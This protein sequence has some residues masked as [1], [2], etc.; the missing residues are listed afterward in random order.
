ML[1]DASNMFWTMHMQVQLQ[2]HIVCN[3]S[4]YADDA[5]LMSA[6]PLKGHT[7]LDI[8]IAVGRQYGKEF[9]TIT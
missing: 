6:Y 8:M 5:T 7:L 2:A 9:A 1:F 3:D 4:S